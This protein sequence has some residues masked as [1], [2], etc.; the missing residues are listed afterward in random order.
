MWY[1]LEFYIGEY[2]NTPPAPLKRELEEQET[3][4]GLIFKTIYISLRF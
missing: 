2:E 4:F 1:G 3:S